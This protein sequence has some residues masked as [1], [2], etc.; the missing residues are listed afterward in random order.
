M[1]AAWTDLRRDRRPS[2]LTIFNSKNLSRTEM[3]FSFDAFAPNKSKGRFRTT[4]LSLHVRQTRVATFVG[5]FSVLPFFVYSRENLEFHLT[6]YCKSI[7]FQQPIGIGREIRLA[8]ALDPWRRPKGSWA[9]GARLV[10][11][12][13]RSAKN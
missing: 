5:V 8:R 4:I 13:K 10:A 6:S 12:Q 1:V 3:I 7:V 2:S 9:L 11:K